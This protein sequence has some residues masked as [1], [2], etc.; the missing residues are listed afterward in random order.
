M[1]KLGHNENLLL[2]L[3]PKSLGKEFREACKILGLKIYD[4]MT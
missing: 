4:F 3:N 2:P 1:L